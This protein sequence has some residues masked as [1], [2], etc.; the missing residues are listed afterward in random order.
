MTSNNRSTYKQA[1]SSPF[2]KF[3]YD[4]GRGDFDTHR[5]RGRD[6]KLTCKYLATICCSK[7]GENGHTVKYCRTKMLT[8]PMVK[9]GDWVG[10]GN[11]GGIKKASR[12]VEPNSAVI[13]NVLGGAFSALVVDDDAGADAVGKCEEVSV[14]V[15]DVVDTSNHTKLLGNDGA[16]VTITWAKKKTPVD[17]FS[18][19]KNAERRS[20]ADMVED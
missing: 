17:L 4:C 7:C 5:T 15:V 18:D 9:A 16:T 8:K 3:C 19:F 2:C 20:W 1:S 12:R 13:H 11:T 14:D 6:G 10:V